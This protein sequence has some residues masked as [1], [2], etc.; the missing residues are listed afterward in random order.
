M[1]KKVCALILG[2]AMLCSVCSAASPSGMK[3]AESESG[4]AS[5]EI[6][7]TNVDTIEGMPNSNWFDTQDIKFSVLMLGNAQKST[8][9]NV[10]ASCGGKSLSDSVLTSAGTSVTREYTLQNVNKGI[11]KLQI[12]VSADGTDV[13]AVSGEY[14]ISPSVEQSPLMPVTRY[15]GFSTPIETAR[16]QALYKNLGLNMTRGSFGQWK[17]IETAKGSYNWSRPDNTMKEHKKA[18]FYTL[19][20]VGLYNPLYTEGNDSGNNSPQTKEHFDAYAKYIAEMANR[21]PELEY[22]EIWNEPNGRKFWGGTKN[23]TDYTYMTEIANHALKKVR[24]NATVGIGSVANGDSAFIDNTYAAGMF[25]YTDAVT[26]HPYVR[27]SKVDQSMVKMAD[28]V[29]NVIMKN[30]GWKVPLNTE[31]GWPTFTG[32]SGTTKE[33]HAI[34]MVKTVALMD[35]YGVPMTIMY[36]LYDTG[37][38]AADAESNFGVMT[39]KDWEPKPAYFSIREFSDQTSGAVSLGKLD[40]GIENAEV[41][42]YLKDGQLIAMGWD[43]TA[44]TTGK[45]VDVTFDGGVSAADIFGNPTDDSGN[46]VTLEESPKYI[47]GLPKYVIAKSLKYNIESILQKR[48]ANF[49]EYADNRGYDKMKELV[50]STLD[51]AKEVENASALPSEDEALSMLERHYALSDE[52]IELY[53]NGELELDNEAVSGI[54]YLNHIIGRLYGN[55]YIASITSKTENA[56]KDAASAYEKASK[57]VKE[58][59]D[60]NTL[61]YSEAILKYAW[62]YADKVQTVSE[63]DTVM[64]DS[65]AKG[66]S[67]MTEIIGGIAEKFA[68]A[69]TVGHD[70]V[71]LQL[72]SAVAKIDLG[73]EK[74]LEVSLYNFR[75]E[76]SLSGYV[77]IT[78]PK[79]EVVGKSENV[80]LNADEDTVVYTP[81]TINKLLDGDY[82]MKFIENGEVIVDRKAG[83]NVKEKVQVQ[84]IASQVT[85]EDIKTIDVKVTNVYGAKVEGTLNVE[86]KGNWK[87]ETNSQSFKLEKDESIVLSF[88]VTAKEKAP[89]HFYMFDLSVNEKDGGLIFQKTTPMDFAAIVKADKEISTANF[90][91]D[92]SDWSNAYPIYMDVPEDPTD[93]EQWKSEDVGARLLMKWD[94]NYY[95]I[96]ADVYDNY[97]A[98]MQSGATIWNGDCIQVAFDTLNDGGTSGS[99]K[100]DDYEYGFAR[101]EVAD[102]VWCWQAA[103]ASGGERPAEWTKILVDRNENLTRYLMRIPMESLAPLSAEEGTKFRFNFLIADADVSTREHAMEYTDG[104]SSGKNPGYYQEFCML[105]KEEQIEGTPEIPIPLDF[106][107]VTWDEGEKESISFAD[108]EGHPMEKYINSLAASGYVKG[109]GDNRFEPDRVVTRAEFTAMVINASGKSA[110]SESRPFADTELAGDLKEQLI[111]AAELGWI[112]NEMA[113]YY[114]E[115]NKPIDREEAFYIANKW[116]E[117]KNPGKAEYRP[118][119]SIEDVNDISAWAAESVQNMY[120]YKIIDGDSGTKMLPKDELSRGAAAKLIYNVLNTK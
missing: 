93:Y 112:P 75:D 113:E 52:I 111:A 35:L 7:L 18:G 95:Y 12:K 103:G 1:K 10:T 40:T 104:I 68:S 49:D 114:F 43:N 82:R 46:V 89:Y 83:I 72:P 70:N 44:W 69:E 25:P 15:L 34:E 109:V 5:A 80:T 120:N 97:H 33:Q 116:L 4:A 55:L 32:G 88:P 98:N 92:I 54:L 90:D 6:K 79:G 106:G 61:S 8:A 67:K 64:S 53:K 118:M 47:K 85:F 37:S 28:M 66:W 51:I 100:S 86:P 87:L 63:I 39:Y 31:I 45:S 20:I 91:G 13:A 84:M 36:Q 59:E 115:P 96:L 62:D 16:G 78:D 101:T 2:L 110:D 26:Y 108:T 9:F 58:A 27:P 71:I 60:I 41:H 11:Q 50:Y 105:G 73:T 38:N 30:G 74:A 117:S 107:G 99:Y 56:A 76:A 19:P 81:T 48:F 65:L 42:L 22:F 77:E 57:I 21:Y 23:P 24:P 119:W 17:T 14:K 3:N 29:H 94:E 102:Q